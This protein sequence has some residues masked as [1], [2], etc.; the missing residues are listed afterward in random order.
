MVGIIFLV[1][2]NVKIRQLKSNVDFNNDENSKKPSIYSIN[3]PNTALSQDDVNLNKDIDPNREKQITPAYVE[4]EL[5]VDN[6][7]EAYRSYVEH[8]HKV[9][10]Y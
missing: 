10:S 2:V 1:Y 8:I 4:N 7:K 3:T 9:R 5:S 6:G